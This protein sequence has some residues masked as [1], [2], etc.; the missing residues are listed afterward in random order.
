MIKWFTV[1]SFGGHSRSENKCQCCDDHEGKVH[2]VCQYLRVIAGQF[3]VVV[4]QV[5]CLHML[6]SDCYMQWNATSTISSP[7]RHRTECSCYQSHHL[8]L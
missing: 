3:H 1:T 5:L 7:F 6:F 2:E 4:T 8:L